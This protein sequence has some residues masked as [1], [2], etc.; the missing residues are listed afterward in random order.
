[1]SDGELFMPDLDEGSP[2]GN[3]F[4][5]AEHDGELVLLC[6]R[7]WVEDVSTQYGTKPAVVDV[8]PVV[9]LDGPH[10]GT[11][12]HDVR[13]FS[14]V[15]VNQLKTAAQQGRPTA[16][17]LGRGVAGSGGRAPWKL[18]PV[19]E[20]EAA[21]AKKWIEKNYRSAPLNTGHDQAPPF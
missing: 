15:L 14:S 5:P 6:C 9:V 2:S 16:G 13:L 17:R 1:M 7:A 18:A 12:Y 21:I 4:R 3:R 10:E 8:D 11:E 19:T 20:D